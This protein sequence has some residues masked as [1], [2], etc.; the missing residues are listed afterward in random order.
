MS[1]RRGSRPAADKENMVEESRC[2]RQKASTTSA[3]RNER[4]FIGSTTSVDVRDSCR[5]KEERCSSELHHLVREGRIGVPHAGCP[6]P[7]PSC[8]AETGRQDT[9]TVACSWRLLQTVGLLCKYSTSVHR[10]QEDHSSGK[11]CQSW[12][13]RTFAT[14]VVHATSIHCSIVSKLARMTCLPPVY[15]K[16]YRTTITTDK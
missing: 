11:R 10:C 7:F 2:E 8:S 15:V 13:A 16:L 3:R 5:I 12:T 6:A 1:E 9:S 14:G 4:A